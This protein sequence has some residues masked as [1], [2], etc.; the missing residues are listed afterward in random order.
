M[1]AATLEII[2][3]YFSSIGSAMAHVIGRTSYSSYV[4]ESGDY[5]AAV[6]TPEGEFFSYPS[7]AGVTNFLG[8]TLTRVIENI[9]GVGALKEGDIIMT[10]DPY[11][12]DGLS[13]HL[14]DVHI[15]KPLFHEGRVAAFAW[16][17]VHTADIGGSVPS[18]LTPANTDIQME[19]LRIPPVKLYEEGKLNEGIRNIYLA[20]TRI[21]TIM[22]GDLN[23]MI[24][25][26]NTAERKFAEVVDKFGI[27]AVNEAMYE[28]L[29]ISERRAR[30]VIE[31]VPDGSYSF[32]DYLDD[33]IETDVPIRV[34]VDIEVKGSDIYLDFSRS[35]PQTHTAFNL[36]TNGSRH[37][38]LYQGLL[39]LIVSEDPFIPITGGITHPFHVNVPKGSIANA[40]YPAAGG[41][42]HPVSLRYYNA[43]LGALARVIPDRLQAA[44]AGQAAIVTLS[45]PDKEQ[46]GAYAATVLEPLG[47]GG[48]AMNGHDGND[49]ID[50][51][52]AYLKNTPI[53]WLEDMTDVLIH[54]Y[55]LVPDSAGPGQYRGGNSIRLDFEPLC[56]DAIVGARGQE[57]MSFQ[58]WGLQSGNAG[59]LGRVLL[60]PGTEDEKELSKLKMIHVKKNQVVSFITPSGGGWGDPYKRDPKAVLSDVVRGLT[61]RESALNDY[62][63]VIA[64]GPDD[65]Y[66]DEKATE[67]YRREHATSGETKIYDFGNNRTG[68]ENRWSSEASDELV[69]ALDSIPY[70]MR[71][72]LKHEAHEYFEDA[73]R[74]LTAEDIRQW[75]AKRIQY[76]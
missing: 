13:T 19:G 17:F 3:N 72:N 51:S 66:V 63:V 20:A 61:S 24:S 14:P 76:E 9:G 34:A 73:E 70:S 21:P 11:S 6:A 69:R 15:I 47:G 49:G 36:I 68:Y 35:D 41:I 38:Y 71:S 30:A 53:E 23:G 46:G 25:A 44:G 4:T 31:S 33:D 10:N 55:E 74:T 12:S 50:S 40:Q 18:S 43:V 29:N 52:S 58:P 75:A 1:E 67:N 62:G 39:A 57:R 5:A 65:A 37:A 28:L 22:W 45:I 26:V 60:D 2:R 27:D 16:C 42:R 59:N 56:D 32:A 8:L 54:R 7:S 64:D 48:G